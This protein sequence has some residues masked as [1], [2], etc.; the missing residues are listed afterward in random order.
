MEVEGIEEHLYGLS[1]VGESL[2]E[3]GVWRVQA[4]MLAEG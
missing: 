1:G 2:N 3:S 4:E